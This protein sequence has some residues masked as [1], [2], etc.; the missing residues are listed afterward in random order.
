M[1]PSNSQAGVSFILFCFK[2]YLVR[3]AQF[4]E[5]GLNGALTSKKTTRL[6][7]TKDKKEW[8]N[9]VLQKIVEAQFGLDP[10]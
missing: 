4:S 9:L 7:T 2:Q 6:K 10:K 8:F 1:R 5:A 3:G